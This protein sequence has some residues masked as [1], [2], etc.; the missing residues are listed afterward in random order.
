M[1][2]TVHFPKHLIGFSLQICQCNRTDVW[3]VTEPPSSL[4]L[5]EEGRSSEHLGQAIEPL[6][7]SERE[8]R[9]VSFEGAGLFL[10]FHEVLI[11]ALLVVSLMLQAHR[12]TA[13]FLSCGTMGSEDTVHAEPGNC[14]SGNCQDS[15]SHTACHLQSIMPP[16]GPFKSQPALGFYNKRL[17]YSKVGELH[18]ILARQW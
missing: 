3:T 14:L 4:C 9:T 17:C 1:A 5:G 2:S 15:S 7:I 11:Q 8:P 10:P 6:A 16:L 12:K 18:I 13:P